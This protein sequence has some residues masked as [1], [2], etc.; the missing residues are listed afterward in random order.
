MHQAE[1][2][3]LYNKRK[4]ILEVAK[5]YKA[6]A[7]TKI[8][9]LGVDKTIVIYKLKLLSYRILRLLLRAKIPEALS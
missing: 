1:N 9:K 5:S 4:A 8:T 3:Q 2:T 7:N 6:L